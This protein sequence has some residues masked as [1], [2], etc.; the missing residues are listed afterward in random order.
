MYDFYPCHVRCCGRIESMFKMHLRGPGHFWTERFG[1][2]F[3]FKRRVIRRLYQRNW[4]VVKL[5]HSRFKGASLSYS[6]I[7]SCSLFCSACQRKSQN[8]SSCHSFLHRRKIWAL[9]VLAPQAWDRPMIYEEIPVSVFEYYEVSRGFRIKEVFNKVC[10]SLSP[11]SL[12]AKGAIWLCSEANGSDWSY[13][14]FV[15]LT[16]GSMVEWGYVGGLP[17][18][19][20]GPQKWGQIWTEKCSRL[21]CNSRRKVGRRKMDVTGT[22]GPGGPERCCLH[23]S[24]PPEHP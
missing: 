17:A 10:L 6:A 12:P 21:S 16:T 7:T 14:L 9:A 1:A 20:V 15:D 24:C 8:D 11:L 5:A 23:F 22:G 2:I 18:W 3:G 19:S 13:L 4:K